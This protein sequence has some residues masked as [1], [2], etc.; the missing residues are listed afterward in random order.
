MT[1]LRM[2]AAVLSVAAMIAMGAVPTALAAPIAPEPAV[3]IATTPSPAGQQ[4]R[5]DDPEQVALRTR[6]DDC[7]SV[8]ALSDV[9]RAAY[10]NQGATQP[11]AYEDPAVADVLR[12]QCPPDSAAD[13][14]GFSVSVSQ[15]DNLRNQIV[16]VGWDSG[17]NQRTNVQ[18]MQCWSAGPTVAPDREQCEFGGSSL[19]RPFEPGGGDFVLSQSRRLG[20]DP[21][22]RSFIPIDLGTLAGVDAQPRPGVPQIDWKGRRG[23]SPAVQEDPFFDTRASDTATQLSL[24]ALPPGF[25]ECAA[26]QSATTCDYEVF[27]Y[28]PSG[29]S[30]ADGSRLPEFIPILSEGY[31]GD[32]NITVDGGPPPSAFLTRSFSLAAAAPGAGVA[33]D[34]WPLGH[35]ELVMRTTSSLQGITTYRL[36]MDRRQVFSDNTFTG[37]WS[38]VRGGDE[39]FTSVPFD[40]FGDR[41]GERPTT[42]TYPRAIQEWIDPRGTNA[43]NVAPGISNGSG[44]VPFEVF[45]DLESQGMA[46]G[47]D[48][49]QAS[50]C[51]LVVV[52]RF[53]RASDVAAQADGPLAYRLWDL[54]MN[55]R[56]S[57]V[58]T[59]NDCSASAD[60]RQVYANDISYTA[61]DSWQS[62]LCRTPGAASNVSR[63]Q[64]DF[65]NREI[66][67]SANRL[68]VVGTPAEGRQS[69]VVAPVTTGGLAFAFAIDERWYAPDST[70]VAGLRN[71]TR[72]TTLNLTPRLVAKLLTQSYTT[73]ALPNGVAGTQNLFLRSPLPGQ[74]FT[75]SPARNLREGTPENLLADKEFLEINP[76]IAVWVESWGGQENLPFSLR[77]NLAGVIYAD[78]ATD[79]YNAM[80]RWILAD[81][82]ARAFLGGEADPNG[83][84]V[85]PYHQGVISDSSD[86][87]RLRDSTCS[88]FLPEAAADLI[89]PLCSSGYQSR[90]ESILD[91]ARYAARG[92][93]RRRNQRPGDDCGRRV[94]PNECNWRSEGR[95]LIERSADTGVALIALTT[96]AS[97]GR[98][99]LPTAA[100]G[101]AAGGFVQ[102]TRSSLSLARDGMTVRGDGILIPS[103]QTYGAG[104]YPLTN[105]AYA[106]VDV[107]RS[108]REQ[109]AGFADVIQYA[110]GGGQQPGLA[111]GQLPPGYAPL[112]PGL[113][114]QA[115]QAVDTLRDDAEAASRCP[116]PPPATAP[117]TARPAPVAPPAAAPVAT[118]PDTRPAPAQAPR[119]AAATNRP[120]APRPSPSPGSPIAPVVPSQAETAE[121]T[122]GIAVA[123]STATTITSGTDRRLL[124]VLPL[125]F[126][127][128][129]AAAAAGPALM[130]AAG[131]RRST[132]RSER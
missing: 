74:E 84:T 66:A 88:D 90:V 39:P 120:A 41:A 105:V 31:S 114:Q 29:A 42:I 122:A 101:T 43:L 13:D 11:P 121:P 99:G 62:A 15:T 78:V 77:S 2:R 117:A 21:E 103:P 119:A 70:P 126:G 123:D 96:T 100:L 44:S 3:T 107:C 72:V 32:T 17:L 56:L 111:P 112:S 109:R 57:F 129:V 83:M 33:D 124:W 49:P 118:S 8:T 130:L 115:Q 71:Q 47:R 55:I 5:W 16:Q 28:P 113:V 10:C 125:V 81:S 25:A 95:Q 27:L 73:G 20:D 110:V 97:A 9:E 64:Q 60:L 127:V 68:G 14:C 50:T 19:L 87:I 128:G 12:G 92:D 54:R 63:P 53:A 69:Q 85:N 22:Y 106:L 37:V 82:D 108:T 75:F 52:P 45:T 116:A 26:V 86:S 89:E 58:P 76:D 30:L 67:G 104:A 38:P 93:S 131:R 48:A 59:T 18:V 94:D 102:P 79:S 23:S 34:A 80:W 91:T 132:N 36:A 7:G 24:D 51:W 46:C 35:Y 40:P 98:L 61:W 4:I 6:R 65:Q 1:R